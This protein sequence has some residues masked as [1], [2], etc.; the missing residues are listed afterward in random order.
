MEYQGD[1]FD[2][3]KAGDTENVQHDPPEGRGECGKE[4]TVWTCKLVWGEEATF[5]FLSLCFGFWDID[6]EPRRV[7]GLRSTS[8]L[9][10]ALEKAGLR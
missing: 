1:K 3:T 6:W 5:D 8:A 9:F 7:Q 4:N 2:T 10:G